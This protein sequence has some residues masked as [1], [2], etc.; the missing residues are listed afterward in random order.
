MISLNNYKAEADKANAPYDGNKKWWQRFSLPPFFYF[1]RLKSFAI[2]IFVFV[3]EHAE[4]AV[5]AALGDKVLFDGCQYCTTRFMGVGAIAE[6]AFLGIL[7]YFF[8]ITA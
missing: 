7:K 1:H 8:E 4:I 3:F 5:V 6:T 2:F